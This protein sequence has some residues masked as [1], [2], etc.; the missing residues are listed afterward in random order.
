MIGT[1]SL[2]EQLSRKNVTPFLFS[3][4][5]LRPVKERLGLSPGSD[6]AQSGIKSGP[7]QLNFKN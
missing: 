3:S 7:L 5:A 1:V 4:L 6:A 2:S